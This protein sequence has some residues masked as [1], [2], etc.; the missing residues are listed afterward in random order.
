MMA[1]L[2][3]F[4]PYIKPYCPGAPDPAIDRALIESA[5]DFANESRALRETITE[6]LEVGV[7]EY[8]LVSDVLESEVFEVMSLKAVVNGTTTLPEPTRL[9]GADEAESGTPTAF[10]YQIGAGLRVW[11][12]PTLA[13]SMQIEVATRP[14]RT[15]TAMDDRLLEQWRTGVVA[16]ALLRLVLLPNTAYSNPQSAQAYQQIF[17]DETSRAYHTVARGNAR[18]RLR[19]RPH[20]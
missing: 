3:A 17:N 2:T 20:P 6:S 14:L 8:S 1:T 18:A 4:Y 9:T 16:G 19:V 10:E 5:I 13:G 12:S 7:T 15:A 11:P